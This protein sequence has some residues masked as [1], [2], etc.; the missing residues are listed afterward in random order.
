MTRI[1]LT[2]MTLGSIRSLSAAVVAGF[3]LACAW[4][5]GI[6][7]AADQEPAVRRVYELSPTDRAAMVKAQGVLLKAYA[8]ARAFDAAYQAALADFESARLQATAAYFAY[9]PSLRYSESVLEFE[10][11]SRKTTALSIPLFSIDKIG[12][13]RSADSKAAQAQATLRIREYE[14][15][16][17]VVTAAAD[18][19]QAC[20]SL[21]TNEARIATLTGEADKAQREYELGQGTITDQRD[22]QVRLDQARATQQSLLARKQTAARAYRT[23]TGEVPKEADFVLMRR[24]KRLAM[25]DLD[26]V[27]QAAMSSNA[28]L[29][30]AYS[31][32]RIA[33]LDHFRAK[34]ALAPEVNY[35][36]S[37]S[38]T[39][40]GTNDTQGIVINFPLQA[41]GVLNVFSSAYAIDKAKAAVRQTEMQVAQNVERFH[42]LVSAGLNESNIRLQAIESAALSVVANEKSFRGGVRTRLDVLN[43]VQTQ[44]QVN[45][46]YVTTLLALAQNVMNLGVQAAQPPEEIV[47]DLQRLLF[48]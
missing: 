4:P 16:A 15:L 9:V 2:C 18:F 27:S 29:M 22:T 36:I 30:N 48:Q 20:E 8:N 1:H 7:M 31:A 24:F 47:L 26:A 38:Q 43:A 17:R 41:G 23:I 13:F 28:E 5:M 33:E 11:Q 3:V 12:T 39:A 19:S 44:F 45:E 10:R 21:R 40:I 35:Q 25:Q 37:K 34:G 6:S 42:T 32:L 14:L 46:D